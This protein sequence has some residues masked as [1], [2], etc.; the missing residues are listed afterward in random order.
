MIHQLDFGNHQVT[1]TFSILSGL[2]GCETK[3]RSEKE[4]R[5]VGQDFLTS[6]IA[7]S[8]FKFSIFGSCKLLI[9]YSNETFVW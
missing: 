9:L 3:I 6:R 4:I 7:K 8:T 5:I 2:G 1:E